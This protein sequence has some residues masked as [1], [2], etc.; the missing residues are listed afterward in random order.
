MSGQT[1]PA[2]QAKRFE[3]VQRLLKRLIDG[4]AIRRD[5]AGRFFVGGK[6]TRK[7]HT[8]ITK[9]LVLVCLAEDWVEAQG[10]YLV[11][12][13]AGRGFL[14]RADATDDFFRQQHQIRVAGGTEVNGSR[15]PVVLNAGESPLGWLR[16]R[17][18]RNGR[19]LI[20]EPQYQAGE[21]LRADYYFAHLSARV[22]SDWSAISPSERS[23][24]GAP[25]NAAAFRD[26]VLAAKD[27]VAGALKSVGP[28]LAGVLIDVCCE[29]K[30][31]EEAEK[32]NGWPQRA[33]KVVLQIALTGSRRFM[34]SSTTRGGRLGTGGCG[35]GVAM[36][37]GQRSTRGAAR[38][39]SEAIRSSGPWRPPRECAPPS[40]SGRSI[41][42]GSGALSNAG[43]RGRPGRQ[44]Q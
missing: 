2:K 21:R 27:R 3:E 28:E 12:S 10:E 6:A 4:G 38:A 7:A 31:L 9:S 35:I 24:R 41:V 19:P 26:D 32:V 33:G 8:A 23:R 22:T 5:T 11:L 40:R 29:L 13:D 25:S 44:S 30:G 16:N 17:K 15:R 39:I 42:A 36:I 43:S 20:A 1:L 14:R 34:V 37:T 18:D